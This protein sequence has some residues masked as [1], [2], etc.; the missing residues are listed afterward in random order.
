MWIG[1]WRCLTGRPEKGLDMMAVV[2]PGVLVDDSD[3]SGNDQ[4]RGGSNRVRGLGVSRHD[5]VPEP[6]PSV[7]QCLAV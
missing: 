7:G 4:A 1:N 3:W 5:M 2:L 6:N